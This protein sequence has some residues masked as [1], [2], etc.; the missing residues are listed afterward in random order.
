[1]TLDVF[2]G[3][4]FCHD[5]A[6]KGK[7]VTRDRTATGTRA[8]ALR[9]ARTAQAPAEA[10][11]QA[12]KLRAETALAKYFEAADQAARIRAA[13]RTRAARITAQAEEAAAAPDAEAANA[14]AELRAL[15]EVNAEIARMCGISV[16]AVRKLAAAGRKD[17]GLAEVRSAVSDGVGVSPG[18]D[19]AS[20][21]PPGVPGAEKAV[22]LAD[23]ACRNLGGQVARRPWDGAHC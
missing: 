6:Y 7:E 9:R 23:A 2:I 10:R 20:E 13:A 16:T 21:G 14:V 4:Q 12:R 8:R 5:V 15:G 11:R 1:L 18:P 3:V 22:F 17:A 19:L